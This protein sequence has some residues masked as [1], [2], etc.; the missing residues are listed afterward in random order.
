MAVSEKGL[1]YLSQIHSKNLPR[2]RLSSI[3]WLSRF[4]KGMKG[5]PIRF[6]GQQF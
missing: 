3:V 2:G 5:L 1:G 4:E 6:L